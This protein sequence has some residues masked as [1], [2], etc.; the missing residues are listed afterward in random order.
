[1][2]ILDAI[3]PEIDRGSL[4]L[5]RST[6]T[7]AVHDIAALS[8]RT[9]LIRLDDE[10]GMLDLILQF[11]ITDRRTRDCIV[12]AVL[13]DH[14]YAEHLANMHTAAA[15]NPFVS[16]MENRGGAHCDFRFAPVAPG[17]FRFGQNGPSVLPI[18]TILVSSALNPHVFFPMYMSVLGTLVNQWGF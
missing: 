18:E 6:N 8:K 9:F 11:N 15:A 17:V 7:G 12:G 10:N 14:E 13:G 1:M 4:R 16:S 2:C 3:S 5:S